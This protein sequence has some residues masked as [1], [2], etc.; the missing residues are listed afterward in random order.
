MK[1]SWVV[2]ENLVQDRI[3]HVAFGTYTALSSL[4][5][6][7][8]TFSDIGLTH[9]TVKRIAGEPEYLATYFPTILPLRGALNVVA[10]LV[11]LGVGWVVG[12]RGLQLGMLAVIGGA[13]L[14]T[15]Y[16]QFLRGTLQA[17]QRF[18]IDA[19]LSVLE[20]VLLLGLVLLL[21]PMGL[22]L[23]GYIWARFATAAFAAV[24]L[25]GLM[26]R[27]FGRVRYRWQWTHA[28]QTLLETLPFALITLL[29]GANER[30]DMVM[31]ER[32][33][34]PTEASYYAGAYRWVD[35]VMMY[36][37]TIMPLF[38]ARFA[39]ASHNRAEQRNLLWF[40][41]R[42]V[43]LP[44]LLACAFVLFRGEL[45][46]WQ[47]THSTSV[48]IDR[49]TLC[50]KIL[51][52]N[53]LVQAFFS[54]YSSLLNSTHYVQT[55]SWLVALSLGLNVVLNVL[56]LPSYGAAAAAFNTLLCAALVSVG[57]VWLV[58]YRAQVAVPWN[59]LARLLTAFVLL[60]AGWYGLQHLFVLPWLVECVAAT[61]GF[62]VLSVGLGLIPLAEVKLFLQRSTN[63]KS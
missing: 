53:V 17:H 62:C 10:L 15:Q 7:L 57:Y 45:L 26:V 51:F 12:Y 46:F 20:K 28:R 32:L 23:Q 22:S 43:T 49:M 5:I 50:L 14:L 19:L 27:F 39:A 47:F 11:L 21:L 36:V 55:V 38:F 59:L 63:L 1:P 25:Y 40:G 37:W 30:V 13:L 35:A 34:S 16:G 41:Q 60:C 29:Y 9:Y 33:A 4:A 58:H 54:V 24:L 2:V 48:E 3:G 52:L 56:L 44:L 61:I 6:I 8:A 31:L 42:V 18:N